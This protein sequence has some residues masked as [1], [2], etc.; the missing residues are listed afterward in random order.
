M[1]NK[2]HLKILKEGVDAWNSW[3]EKNREIRPNLHWATL[4]GV[5]L[6][7]ANLSKANLREADLSKA[8]LNWAILTGANLSKADLRGA[9]LYKAD[10]RKADLIGAKFRGANVTGTD[11][12][13]I[14][15]QH[16]PNL[17]GAH[18]T[19]TSLKI[20]G[21]KEGVNGFYC[22]ETDSAAL[23]TLSPPG[24]SMQGSNAD[25]VIES[26]K[27]ARRLH[28]SSLALI[29]FVLLIAILE[30]SQPIKFLNT[31]L[32][33]PPNRFGLLAMPMAVGLLGLAASF[34]SDALTGARYLHDRNSAMMVGNFPWALS[35]YG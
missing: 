34:M 11:F 8:R 2:E 27:R 22:K 30:I 15:T 4:T 35:K 32:E 25:V 19:T 9:N 23:M 13:D 31:N 26:L 28:G 1:A 17:S 5:S 21:C 33:I 18:V 10:L 12:S 6:R 7:G 24:D 29:G 20:K 3:R 16:K 14:D